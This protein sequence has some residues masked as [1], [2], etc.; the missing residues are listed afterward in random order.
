MSRHVPTS[1]QFFSRLSWLDGTP[2][3]EHVEPYRRRLFTAAL[4]TT[5]A[6]GHPRYTLI[7]TGRAKKNFKTCDLVLASL[8]KL[9]AWPSPGGSQCYLLAN[10]EAQA[11]DDLELAVKLIK[12]NPVLRDAVRLKLKEIRRKDG[13]GFLEILPAKDV[14]GT[15]GKTFSFCGFDEIHAYRNWDLLESLQPDPTRLDALTWI[16]SY[17]SIYHRPGVPLFD[18]CQRGRAGTDPR[19]LFSW[20]AADYTTDPDFTRASPEDRANPS[21][22]SWVDQAYLTQQRSRLPAHKFRR[23]HLNLPGLP[24]GSAFQPEPVMAAV[25]RTVLA[26]PWVPDRTYAAFVD[27][28]G[29]SSEDA[30]LAI[31]YADAEGRAVVCRVLDQGQPPPFDPRRAVARFVRVLQEYRL[32]GVTGDQYAG[33]TFAADFGAHGIAYRPAPVPKHGLYEALEPAL[34]SGRVRLP[35][36][37]ALE[38]Q[39]LGL[40]WRG[41]KIDHLPGEQDDLANAVAGLVH[42][43]LAGGV[44][45][46]EGAPVLTGRAST[47]QDG[48]VVPGRGPVIVTSEERSIR[49]W[50]A[51]VDGPGGAGSTSRP[52]V[53][54]GLII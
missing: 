37:P 9:L 3:I 15:H 47:Y 7:L 14:A 38:Q 19:M 46:G 45:T 8:Y 28:S 17:A 10:D 21:R 4:D 40:V 27:M 44:T 29:G 52:G 41:S 20:Y 42:L 53:R 39:L 49:R 1:L 30:T 48:C 35:N 23:L 24:E 18:L 31:G 11:A 16:T 34:N 2:L 12:A 22:G 50:Q 54:K 32:H 51:A 33:Q 25:D 43:L 36:V 5:D 13:R 6:Q 26:E